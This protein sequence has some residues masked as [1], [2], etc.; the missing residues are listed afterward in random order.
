MKTR[1]EY[2]WL[3]GQKP[4][5]GLRSKARYVPECSREGDLPPDWNFD[6]GSTEVRW[7]FVK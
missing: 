2:I 6:G 4:L 3:D 7:Y 1:V 5:A